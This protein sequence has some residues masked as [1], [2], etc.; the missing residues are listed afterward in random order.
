[1]HFLTAWALYLIGNLHKF[2][3]SRTEE[4]FPGFKYNFYNLLQVKI[5]NIATGL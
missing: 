5:L 2:P 4:I 1:L 3:A